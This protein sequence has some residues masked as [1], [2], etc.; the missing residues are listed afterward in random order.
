MPRLTDLVRVRTL[1]DRD[2]AWAAYAIGDLSPEHQPHCEWHAP[3]DDSPAL[4]LLYRGFAPPILFAMGDAP[5]VGRLIQEVD[6]DTLS[7]HVRGDALTALSPEYVPTDI[8]PM[9]RMAVEPASFR[10]APSGDVVALDESHL[11]ELMTLYEDGRRHD[12]GPT[13]FHRSMLR[14]GTFR[15]VRRGSELVA[16][17]GT[18]LFSADLGVCTI[19]NVYTRRDHRRQGLAARVTSEVVRHALSHAI[20]TIVLNVGQDNAAAHAVYE[21]LGFRRYCEF[22]E[23]EASRAAIANERVPPL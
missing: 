19:G 6:A 4:L 2:R 16:V 3:A 8:R 10:P 21:R 20:P 17:A 14:Q 5:A 12:E 18:H 11:A 23:G 13:F 15:G 22:F 7:M 1:L 9:C